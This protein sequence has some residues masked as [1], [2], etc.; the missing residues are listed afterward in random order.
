MA[1]KDSYDVIFPFGK[2]KG[3]SLGFIHDSDPS[4]VNWLANNDKMPGL[5]SDAAKRILA[6]E[7][8]SDLGLP[9]SRIEP[10]IINVEMWVAKKNV[11]HV[12]F[13]YDKELLE[14]FKFEIDGRKWDADDRCWTVPAPQILKMIELFGGVKNI[15][16][17]DAVKKLFREEKARRAHLD[18]IRVKEDTDIDIGTKLDL[19]PYQKVAVEFIGRAGGRA[20]VADQMGL[21]KT[22]TAIGYAHYHSLKTLIICPK[23]VVVNWAREIER[24]TGKKTTIWATKDKMGRID[25][26]YHVIN[27]DIVERR[28]DELR[29]AGFELMVCDEATFLKNRQTKRAKSILG[30]YKQRKLYPGIKTKHVIFL[31]GTPILNRPIEA[32][33][34]LNFLDKDRFSN[35]FHF[36]QKYG[37]W[38]GEDGRNLDDLHHRTKDLIIR[39]LKKDILSEL[40]P[41][42]RNDL[43]VEL[44]ADEQKEYQDLLNKLFRKWKVLGKPTIAEMPAIQ[45]YLTER[46]MPRLIEMI[47]EMLSQDRG[48]LIYSCYVE[49]LKQLAKH[50]G[51]QSA[52]IHGQLNTTERQK[53]IDALTNGTA[54]VGL[55]SIGAAAMGIDGLQH[56]IDTVVFLN[57]WWV[58]AI[59]EQA[60]DRLF[61]IGQTKQVQAYYMTCEN[62]IDEYMGT[63]LR[64][65]QQMIDQVVD[66][67]LLNFS[68]NKS[69]FG[70]FVR[71]LKKGLATP[72][73]DIDVT[74]VDDSAELPV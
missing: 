56:N 12:S 29:K 48:I 52:M 24:F 23:S 2:H 51:K 70:E 9:T 31:T 35:F 42:Q 8:I 17:D 43:Y 15:T 28:M 20:M 73:A 21:G 37:G 32:F 63:I 11:I 67:Q 49:P 62:T 55:F 53:A 39:R 38:K 58:P 44:T 26:Q 34:L 41:K 19:Y 72:L 3:K 64:E 36:T 54:K 74:I 71:A 61:R 46:K 18:E 33:V 13:A 10:K 22:A 50:Y 5:W 47:D 40:P 4:Y 59:H 69:V 65:K 57:R 60:E 66:G 27:Y 7:S 16:A 25:A 1:P 30:D 14:R 45:N 68:P 6:N